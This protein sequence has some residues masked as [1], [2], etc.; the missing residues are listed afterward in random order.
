LLNLKNPDPNPYAKSIKKLYTH[1]I[2]I[3]FNFE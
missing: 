1:T 3:F 2:T